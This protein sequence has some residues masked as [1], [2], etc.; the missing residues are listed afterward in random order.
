MSFD[1][2]ALRLTMPA[3]GP[4]P[5][6]AALAIDVHDRIESVAA[7][8][9]QL[10]SE[11]RNSL[12]QSLAWC[13]AW[14][15]THDETLAILQGTR[16]GET[17]LLLPLE[18]QRHNMVRTA[19]FI[20]TRFTNI[21]TGLFAADVWEHGLGIGPADLARLIATSLGGRADLVS[22]R[23]IPF[24]WRGSRHPLSSL[25]AHEH[26]NRT[27]QLPLLGDFTATIDQLNGKRRRKKFRNQAR[28]I[29]A[30]GGYEHFVAT[31]DADRHALMQLFF[32]QKAARFRAMG[33]PDVFQ[34]ADVQRF[35]HALAQEP[36]SG[37]DIPLELHALILH[38][39]FEGSIAAIAGLSRKGDHVI[40][41]FGSIDET[42]LPEASPGE[43]LFWLAIERACEQ[44]AALFDF[45]LGDQPYKRRWCTIET[46]QSDILLP[47]TSVGR[48]AAAAQRGADRA[49]AA[50]KANPQL[51]A[52][53]QRIR[54]RGDQPAATDED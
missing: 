21:N 36:A 10:E 23:N 11:S 33:L 41:Q 29:E 52:L 25:P 3:A 46:V 38:G 40:C 43:M 18:I 1:G 42:I 34:P 14:T 32:L 30:T 47:V 24:H 39:Q 31:S 7:D 35:F 19:Q 16:N 37:H 51:Y 49:K 5:E 12:H 2:N 17:V 9:R 54:A 45:G 44:G 20:A 15:A 48:L 26:L 13:Q 22:L 8:W 6:H 28:K 27:F 4:E 50:I 53:V